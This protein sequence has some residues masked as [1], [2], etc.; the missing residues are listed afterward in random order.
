MIGRMAEP[1]TFE[2]LRDQGLAAYAAFHGLVTDPR[3]LAE[4]R[5]GAEGPQLE[6]IIEFTKLTSTIP[7]PAPELP[8]SVIANVICQAGVGGLRSHASLTAA[9][10]R[11]D[12]TAPLDEWYVPAL[13]RLQR[14][15]PEVLQGEVLWLDYTPGFSLDLLAE[16]TVKYAQHVLP[17]QPLAGPLAVTLV[18]LRDW[19]YDLEPWLD[20]QGYSVDN[21]IWNLAELAP[22]EET[23][24]EWWAGFESTVSPQTPQATFEALAQLEALRPL[25]LPVATT[26]EPTPDEPAEPAEPE[27]TPDTPPAPRVEQTARPSTTV[28]SD[29]STDEDQLEYAL[30]A[31]AIASFVRDERTR[32]PLTIGIKAP[33][34]A[35]KTSLMKMI[36]KRLDPNP[37]RP[38]ADAP[39]LKIKDL[40][41]QTRHKSPEEAADALEPEHLDPG[42]RRTTI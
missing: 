17:D 21:W 1:E 33:W 6:M 38:R 24:D 13:N 29:L 28:S 31:D 41:R 4:W 39:R 22:K 37:P 42:D 27:P 11:H 34:G 10:G 26:S 20:Q 18:L 19:A 25:A 14:L 12:A 5:V 2:R 15:V 32:A 16:R 23:K 30:Y 7:P 9:T 40:W 8:L 36:R 35:G 3:A